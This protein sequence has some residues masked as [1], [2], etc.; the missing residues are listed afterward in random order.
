MWLY[1]KKTESSSPKAQIGHYDP[2]NPREPCL[3]DKMLIC[4]GSFKKQLPTVPFR[5]IQRPGPDWKPLLGI[6][7]N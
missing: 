5:A 7:F 2:L 1:K 3:L 6:E 4:P